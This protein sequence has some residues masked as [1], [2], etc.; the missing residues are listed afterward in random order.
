MN[1]ESSMAKPDMNRLLINPYK[2]T[3]ST[4]IEIYERKRS[5]DYMRKVVNGED[6][7]KTLGISGV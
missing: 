3:D 7:K 2:G 4:D 5:I 6:D 1:G